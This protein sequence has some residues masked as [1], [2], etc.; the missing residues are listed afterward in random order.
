MVAAAVTA[1][2]VFVED[3]IAEHNQPLIS[4]LFEMGV[5]FIEEENGIRV[6]GP[7]TLKPTEDITTSRFPN[8]YASTND[9]CSI[10]SFRC[11]HNDRNSI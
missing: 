3:A 5:R 7:E 2:N 9:D 1:G 11:Q 8:R 4:K 10:T 6:I